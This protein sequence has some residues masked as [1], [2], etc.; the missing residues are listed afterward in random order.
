MSLRIRLEPRQH[1]SKVFAFAVT[2]SSIFVALTFC[3]III[4][5]QGFDPTKVYLKLV[6]GGFGSL[7]IMA[8][9]ILQSIPLMLCGLGVAMALKMSINNIGA[10]GQFAIGAL[11]TSGVVLFFDDLPR[12]AVVLLALLAGFLGG[13]IWGMMATAPKAFLGVNETIIT[14]MFNYVALY[15]VDY[16]C[17][18][19]WRDSAGSNMPYTKIFS[20]HTHLNTFF[21]TRIHSGIVIAI[22]SA[23]LIQIFYR[24][25][26]RGYQVRVIGSNPRAASYAGMNIGANIMLIMMFSGGLAGLAGGTYATGVVHRL[27]PGMAS[28]AGY[29]AIII[30]YLAKFNPF[31]VLLVA[32]L[33][34]GLNQGGY[35][36][37]VMGISYRI[38]T[39]IQ[40][41]ILLFVLAG[42]IF[43]RYRVR[44]HISKDTDDLC[45]ERTD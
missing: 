17:Y 34:G 26:T 44:I 30:A 3:A 20:E 10:E 40:G 41:A 43:S 39:M 8:E 29:T 22:L 24:M 4:I 32:I 38:V 1:S 23:V 21:G 11:C 12:M 18:G 13:A 15:F 42:E 5:L 33:F 2:L 31:G 36:V 25:T 28:G 16:W 9:S 19:P 7:A 45:P 35:S 6:M 14:L 37:Q 27:Q